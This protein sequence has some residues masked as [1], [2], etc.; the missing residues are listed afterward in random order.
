MDV[1]NRT[2][3]QFRELFSRM[4]P[5]QRGTLIVVPLLVVA[6]FAML[7][8]SQPGA[9]YTALS[10]GKVFSTDELM[11]TEQALIEANLT[12]FRREGQR[13]MVPAGEAD[14]YNAALLEYDA[15]PED[16]GSELL[17]KFENLGPFSTDRQRQDMKEALLLQEL[18]RMIMAVPDIE[19]A[20]VG[21]ANS[22][23]PSSW[24]RKSHVTANVTVRP[25][26]G[27]ELSQRLVTSLRA[28]VSSMVPDLKPSD[29]TIFDVVNAVSYTGESPDDPFNSG[30]VNRIRELTRQYEQ[31]IQKD[32]S[33]I[34][35][36]GVTVHVDV[37]NLKSSVTRSQV[38]DPKKSADVYSSEFT[39]TDN[40]QQRPP[41]GEA[42]LRANQPGALAAS[43]AP[44][45]TRQ[46][47]ETGT[48][49]IR[50]VSFEVTEKALIAAMP[51]A[52][53]VSV[54]I[55]RDY[56]REIA[57]QRTAAG[58]K[59][60]T[61]TDAVQI[62]QEVL[63]SVQKSVARLI[64]TGSP[65]EAI[66][67]TSFE[68]VATDAA[69]PPIVWSIRVT[70]LIRQW[71]GPAGMVLLALAALVILRR[72]MKTLPAEASSMADAAGLTAGQTIPGM[73]GAVTAPAPLEE[74]VL[75]DMPKRE[76]IQNLARDNP[77]M[78]AN[79]IGK[80]LQAVK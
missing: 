35:G 2:A 11:K 51:K 49:A 72:Q 68:R 44:E 4:T 71:G 21:I 60:P 16:M 28:A 43:A 39:T 15:M 5:S 33:Y 41:K 69:D 32:L 1:L 27:R 70:D 58:E 56:Y 63:A 65:V 66:T 61:R 79:V 13:I 17:R 22:G 9:S 8:W 67:V 34:P 53:Q 54:K 42:G 24:S 80:W 75:K 3:R 7:L 77:E 46:L 78:T 20:R 6:A 23:R 47:N 31:Q 10:W 64:P 25:R 59:D 73:P 36:V 26:A 74:I 19:H 45:R 38:V 76:L 18:Q 29:V 62:E 55:P 50:G 57:D 12:G 40:V 37:D 30:P 52:V 14:R 48:N